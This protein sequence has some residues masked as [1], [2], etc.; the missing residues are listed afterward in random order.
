VYNIIHSHLNS[1]PT[2][3]R[4]SPHVLRHSFA[5]EMLNNGADINAVKELLGH[6]SLA[7]TQIYTHV[8]LEE[9]K[10]TYDLAHPRAH[11]KMKE[12]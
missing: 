2:L 5:T 6:S 9:M 10:K 4:R 3:S 1:I 12:E 8:T 11:N 7:S